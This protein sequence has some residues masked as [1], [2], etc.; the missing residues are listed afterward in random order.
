MPGGVSLL[1]K[2]S[3]CW[4]WLSINFLYKPSEIYFSLVISNGLILL[5]RTNG[6]PFSVYCALST[7]ILFYH[8]LDFLVYPNRQ[9][10]FLWFAQ[11]VYTWVENTRRQS[12]LLPQPLF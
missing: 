8:L 10:S 11:Y 1:S 7:S 12:D 6:M 3:H 2:I 5:T 9:R 4:G